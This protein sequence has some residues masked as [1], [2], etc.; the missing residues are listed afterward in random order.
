MTKKDDQIIRRQVS[1]TNG[2]LEVL[3]EWTPLSDVMHGDAL[4]NGVVRQI[5]GDQKYDK[6][7][8]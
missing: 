6:T 4:V 7:D 8:K 5:I 3:K 2:E 1:I